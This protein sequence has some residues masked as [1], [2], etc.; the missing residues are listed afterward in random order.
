MKKIV[1]AED[2][3]M[4]SEIYQK[5]FQEQDFEVFQAFSGDQVLEIVKKNKVD[6]VLLDLVLPK[7]D[8]FAVIKNLKSADYD[9]SVKVI[10]FSNLSQREDRERALELGADGF[11]AK[12][13]F[14]PSELV[15]EIKRLMSQQNE[16][17]IKIA[18]MRMAGETIADSE[19]GENGG[20]KVLM[21]EDGEI[22]VDI[23]GRRLEDE[24]YR[25]TYADTGVMGVKEAVEG[26]FDLI[27][28]DVITP[29]MNG[30]EIVARLRDNEKTK[31]IPLVLFYSIEE[32]DM[33]KAITDMGVA[34]AFLKTELLP[35]E[36][37]EEINKIMSKENN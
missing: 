16:K 15:R 24:G 35:N 8:G 14:S 37:A 2:D 26:D 5:K 27:I 31:D 30:D 6:V 36:F 32:E 4:I 1:L 29:T 10:V 25:M 33:I 17:I 21:I 28:V 11:V 13:E 12:S 9:P 7:M 3:P 34:G 22:F 18:Q 20:K 19:Y 23:F